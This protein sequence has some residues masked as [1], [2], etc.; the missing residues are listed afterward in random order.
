LAVF[1]FLS[2]FIVDFLYLYNI[3]DKIIFKNKIV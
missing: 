3:K 1:N 2:N